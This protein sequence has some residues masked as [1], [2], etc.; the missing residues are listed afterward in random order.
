M[1]SLSKA[2]VDKVRREANARVGDM[3]KAYSKNL[4]AA[5]KKRLDAA[6]ADAKS[7]IAKLQKEHE[8]FERLMAMSDDELRL[9]NSMERRDESSDTDFMIYLPDGSGPS[10][11]RRYYHDAGG[12]SFTY[13]RTSPCTAVVDIACGGKVKTVVAEL[14]KEQE[15]EAPDGKMITINVNETAP[16]GV[17]LRAS[18]NYWAASYDEHM[19][20]FHNEAIEKILRQGSAT[21]SGSIFLDKDG[22]CRGTAGIMQEIIER[23]GSSDD[24]RK[25][26]ERPHRRRPKPID[27]L[28]LHRQAMIPEHVSNLLDEL[29]RRPESATEPGAKP[30]KDGKK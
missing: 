30:D 13:Q 26:A 28:D 11:N 19:M 2:Y 15:V 3:K 5:M 12:Y 18:F 1:A 8:R 7:K 22:K 25:K 6:R 24:E 27:T 20:R 29:L 23:L 10:A 14:D 4:T 17:K 21:P 9:K 16:F